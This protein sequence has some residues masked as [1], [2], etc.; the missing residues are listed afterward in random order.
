V[1]RKNC[2]ACDRI[3]AIKR[4][5]NPYFVK[6][7]SESYLVLQDQQSTR[8]W[9]VLLLKDHHEH[10]GNLPPRRAKRIFEDVLKTAE[11]IKKAFRPVRINYE[12]LGN[13]LHHIH[14]HIIPRHRND[15]TPLWP[16]WLWGKKKL[17]GK[18]VSPALRRRLI[19][20]LRRAFR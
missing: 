9:C 17:A 10:L 12:C 7:L 1:L 19:I 20:M 13:T 5:T 3:H 4:G 16:V 18:V 8:G 14:W 11:A 6:E 2:F 15:P